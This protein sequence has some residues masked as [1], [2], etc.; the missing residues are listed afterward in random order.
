MCS[1]P[2]WIVKGNLS[3]AEIYI[4]IYTYSSRGRE[5]RWAMDAELAQD[6]PSRRW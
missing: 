5:Q 2:L 4:Y 3:L 1:F 6:G